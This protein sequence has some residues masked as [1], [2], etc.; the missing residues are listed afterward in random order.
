MQVRI[1][2]VTEAGKFRDTKSWHTMRI[3]REYGTDLYT[4]EELK[5]GDIVWS[6]YNKGMYDEQG[7]EN[8]AS[9]EKTFQENLKKQ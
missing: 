1:N 8:S 6:I 9:L 4:R 5:N 7:E 3:K 2:E